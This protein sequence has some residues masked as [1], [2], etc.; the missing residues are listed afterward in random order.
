MVE[1]NGN[2]QFLDCRSLILL[3][4]NISVS[5]LSQTK[6]FEYAYLFFDFDYISDF[7][8]LL[9]TDISEQAGNMPCHPLDS[10][11]SR[12]IKMYFNLIHERRQYP[13]IIKGLLFSLI[14]EIG[15]L[16]TGQ[17]SSVE[18][19][20]Q[21]KTAD[22]FFHLLHLHYK[23]RQTADFYADKLCVSDKHLMRTIK[24]KTGHTFHFWLSDFLIREAKLQLRSTD[25]TVTQIA[26][27]LHFPNPSFFSRFFRK[28][29]GLTPLQFRK[30]K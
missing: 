8:L 11:K 3:L 14:L 7:P 9:N 6:N 24:K 17:S 13:I 4:P 5:G 1:I 22:S 2:R 23:E 15:Q 16:Y 19:S 25:K 20:R 28:H 29:T 26:E 10:E 21:T 18:I 27:E 12:L 30:S